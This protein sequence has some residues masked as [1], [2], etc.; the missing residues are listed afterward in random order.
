MTDRQNIS[1]G[2]H[3]EDTIGYSRAVRVGDQVFVSGCTAARSDGTVDAV[4]DPHAQMALALGVIE[5]ALASA[6]AC[7]SDVVRTRSFVTDMTQWAEMARAHA[8]FFR[9]V[10]PAA[11]VVEIRRLIHPDM[12]VEVEADAVIDRSRYDAVRPRLHVCRPTRA[13]ADRSYGL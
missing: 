8:D 13:P 12:L 9:D 10:K 6:G 3:W 2:G 7:L 5:A 1:S 11:T 4:G